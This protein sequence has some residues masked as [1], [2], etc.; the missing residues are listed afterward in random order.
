MRIILII[1]S[2]LIA[3]PQTFAQEKKTKDSKKFNYGVSLSANAPFVHD[4]KTLVNNIVVSK[5]SKE[6]KMAGNI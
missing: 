6:T 4:R 2:L 1:I 3:L 5:P